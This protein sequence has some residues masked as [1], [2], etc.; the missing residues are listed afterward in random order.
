MIQKILTAVVFSAVV[1]AILRISPI[2]P[3]RLELKLLIILAVLLI[4]TANA[5]DW[6]FARQ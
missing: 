3:K 5:F 2:W 1:V 6:S 4:M